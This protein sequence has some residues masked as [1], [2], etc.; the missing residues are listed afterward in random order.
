MGIRRR[1]NLFPLLILTLISWALF[2]FIFFLV[3]P[4]IIRDFP[5]KSLY[6][7]FFFTLFLSIFFTAALILSHSR[8]GFLVA[9]GVI[10]FLYLRL[11]GLGHILNG[12]LLVSFFLILELALSRD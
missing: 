11:I 1:K 12:I 6:F 8:R 4:E 2:S 10:S 7:P 9:V 5:F 3:N